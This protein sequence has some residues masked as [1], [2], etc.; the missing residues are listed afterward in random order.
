MN[1]L[2]DTHTIIWFLNGDD[3][4]SIKS[5]EIIE[6]QDNFGNKTGWGQWVSERPLPPQAF[7][8]VDKGALR[9]QARFMPPS[10]GAIIKDSDINE[11]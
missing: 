5:K 3:K 9:N 10:L 6:N 1:Y 4:I 2:L 7:A 8:T 11:N